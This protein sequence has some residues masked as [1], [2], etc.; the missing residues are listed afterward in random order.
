[1]GV[2]IRGMEMPTSCAVCPFENYGDCYGGKVKAIMDIDD[3]VSAGKR[4]PRCPLV[5]IPPHG[6]LIDVKSLENMHFTESVYDNESKLFV[7]FVEVASAI[8]NAPTIIEGES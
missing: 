1:M 8:F 3:Y 5:E 7:P 2:Y 6:R 4:H